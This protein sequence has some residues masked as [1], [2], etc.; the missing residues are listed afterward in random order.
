MHFRCKM[1]V[2]L[3]NLVEPVTK[4]NHW[5]GSWGVI[6]QHIAHEISLVTSNVLIHGVQIIIIHI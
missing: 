1:N 4:D 6:S 5:K 3:C 2:L